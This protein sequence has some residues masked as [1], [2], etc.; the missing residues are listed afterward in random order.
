M[1][2]DWEAVCRLLGLDKMA[3]S[4]AMYGGTCPLC[5]AEKVFFVWAK[6]FPIIKAICINCKVKIKITDN[7]RPNWP[8]PF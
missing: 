4:E 6:G 8:S 2:H 7:G 5:H 3:M 1:A